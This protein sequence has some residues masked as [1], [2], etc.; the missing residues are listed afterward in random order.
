MATP[1]SQVAANQQVD[2]VLDITPFYPTGG[3]QQADVGSITAKD[4]EFKVEDVQ[5]LGAAIVHRGK[6]T[7][8][9][10]E[11]GDLVQAR[12]DRDA[13]EATARNHTATHLLHQALPQAAG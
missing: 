5:R 9:S 6:V 7:A 3:G 10:L 12:V 13:R 1:V 8:G 4:G 2:V 11:V